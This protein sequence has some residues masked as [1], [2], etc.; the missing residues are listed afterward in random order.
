MAYEPQ[1][2]RRRQRRAETTAEQLLQAARTVFETRGYQA[3]TV[4]TITKAASTAHGTFYL[5]FRNKQDAVTRMYQEAQAPWAAH[6][7]DALRVAL[8]GFLQVFADHRGLWRALIEGALQ[9]AE[10]EKMWMELRR[11]FVERIERLLERNR[12]ASLI[13]DEL[14]TTV[15]AHALGSMVEWFAFAHY[16]LGEPGE[17]RVPQDRV[18][19]GLVD[20]WLHAAFAGTLAPAAVPALDR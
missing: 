14:D 19:D 20:V 1:Q 7:R 6:P 18:V 9:D 5:Y 4:G 16:A 13:R 17:D 10:I 2:P 8:S 12:Q 15:A 3:A 11:P